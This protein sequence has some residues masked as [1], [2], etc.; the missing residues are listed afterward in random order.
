VQYLRNK[1]ELLKNL[2][3]D[4]RAFGGPKAR[5]SA[6]FTHPDFSADKLEKKFA[7]Y[8]S[9]YVIMYLYYSSYRPRFKNSYSYILI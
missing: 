9:K 4:S 7:N 5:K 1:K 3:S 2:K 6:Y 8:A